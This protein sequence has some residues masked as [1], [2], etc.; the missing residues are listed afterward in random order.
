MERQ[1]PRRP[2]ATI[3]SIVIYNSLDLDSG[4][5]LPLTITIGSWVLL[6]T[7]KRKRGGNEFINSYKG[8]VKDF[9]LSNTGKTAKE[10]LIQHAYMHSE[11]RLRESHTRLPTNR[12][13]C[14]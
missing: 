5:W 10:V 13:N 12:P 6:Q 2:S 8:R 3:R 9:K 14:E 11:L 4:Q 1:C 7:R